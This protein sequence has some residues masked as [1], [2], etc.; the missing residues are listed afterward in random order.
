MEQLE[1]ILNIQ[2]SCQNQSTAQGQQSQSTLGTSLLAQK[3][4]FMTALSGISEM[5]KSWVVDSGAT[6]HM[7]G[8]ANLFHSYKEL[9]N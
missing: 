5:T 4:T 6:D 8:Y 9:E 3:G 7:T 1:Q 2:L